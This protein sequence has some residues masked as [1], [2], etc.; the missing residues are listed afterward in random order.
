[1]ICKNESMQSLKVDAPKTGRCERKERGFVTS[2]ED[3]RARNRVV[4]LK[5]AKCSIVD[6]RVPEEESRSAR[7]FLRQFPSNL[8]HDEDQARIW[9]TG[10][11]HLLRDDVIS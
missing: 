8:L 11:Q 2:L 1:M 7:E 3:N 9:L 4:N 10:K 6:L 5:Q